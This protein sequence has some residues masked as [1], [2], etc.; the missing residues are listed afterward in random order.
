[1]KS[2]PV[3]MLKLLRQEHPEWR[4][5]SLGHTMKDKFT[6]NDPEHIKTPQRIHRFKPGMNKTLCADNRSS[7]FHLWKCM[8]P[9]DIH[10]PVFTEIAGNYLRSQRIFSKDPCVAICAV[11]HL[12]SEK[13]WRRS[14]RKWVCPR[15]ER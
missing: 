4:T 8:V 5:G 7:E 11:I 15:E 12:G 14:V 10:F 3:W 2:I 13:Q 1:M 9:K 6:A